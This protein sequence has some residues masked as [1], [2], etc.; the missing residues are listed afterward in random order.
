MTQTVDDIDAMWSDDD[1][2]KKKKKGK[3]GGKNAP[4]NETNEATPDQQVF[5]F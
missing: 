3:K 1:D 5:M 2:K 4:N